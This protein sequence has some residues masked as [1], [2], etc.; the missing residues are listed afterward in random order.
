M[1]IDTKKE[2][3]HVRTEVEVGVM[4]PQATEHQGLGQPP[5]SRRRHGAD[6]P[7]RLQRER[8]PGDT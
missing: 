7:G 6:P 8:G 3:G 5:G 1:G 4:L 2:D